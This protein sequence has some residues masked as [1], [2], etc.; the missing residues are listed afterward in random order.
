MSEEKRVKIPCS[1]RLDPALYNLITRKAAII[2]MSRNR[3]IEESLHRMLKDTIFIGKLT[4]QQ[5]EQLAASRRYL[6]KSLLDFLITDKCQEA[7]FPYHA[8]NLTRDM[9]AKAIEPKPV[10]ELVRLLKRKAK[11]LYHSRKLAGI[12][13]AIEKELRNTKRYND[14]R[15]SARMAANIRAIALFEHGKNK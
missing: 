4:S 10:I 7:S 2:G 5:A 8:A 3:F 1:V 14:I 11:E 12:F 9:L 15:T 13:N 6:D